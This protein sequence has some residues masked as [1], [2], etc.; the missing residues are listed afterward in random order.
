M[1]SK[2]HRL[3]KSKDV[4]LV[5]TRGRGFFNPYFTIK[6]TPT[7][8]DFRCT[9]VVSTKV[10]KKAVIRNK[11]KRILRD[12]LRSKQTLLKIGDY[13]IIVKQAAVK[14]ESK[15]LRESAVVLLEK[16]KLLQK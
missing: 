14:L 6:F 1:F 12:T 2:K 4:K 5:L 10:S 7:L 13:V 3:A 8:K 15:F 9:I 16:S 11:L